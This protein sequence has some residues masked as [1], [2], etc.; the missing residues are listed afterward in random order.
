MNASA[1]GGADPSFAV[2]HI[3][4]FDYTF[5]DKELDDV[6]GF[7][8]R[9]QGRAPG[10]PYP[11]PPPALAPLLGT[12]AHLAPL[13]FQPHVLGQQQQQAA[14]G[15]GQGLVSGQHAGHGA[16]Y[17]YGMVNFGQMVGD[18]DRA[19]PF[20]PPEP[21]LE[22]LESP[23][24]LRRTRAAWAARPDGRP[25]L[26][27]RSTGSGSGLGPSPPPA[28]R[29][30]KPHISHSTVEKQRRD[31]INSLI[32][33]LRELVPP[34]PATGEAPD[35]GAPGGD[36]RR[37]KHV[38]L[39]DTILLVRGLQEK[40]HLSETRR[41]GPGGGSLS[42]ANDG[43]EAPAELQRE[44]MS[45]NSH[46]SSESHPELPQAPDED[47][48]I[49]EGVI[50]EEGAEGGIFNVKVHCKD[51]AGLLADMVRALKQLPLEISSAAVTTTRH[52]MVSDV[53]QVRQLKGETAAP[54]DIRLAVEEVVFQ[55]A[56]ALGEK[57]RRAAAYDD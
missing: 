17:D 34:Q 52:G 6:L 37:P 20:M 4:E 10:E 1:Q 18:G 15:L 21:K 25:L 46:R 45:A 23:R 30:G 55:Q 33:E 16:G 28:R 57:K 29:D 12:T 38:V 54:E 31:R 14:Y 56:G 43:G 53:F 13:Q 48:A 27:A 5:T 7:M 35:L 26:G 51:R 11:S 42:S 39:A 3:G 41:G 22:T 2:G 8:E 50:V 9:Q 32:D 24:A 49:E 44:Q 19:S 47:T 36:Q 40:L